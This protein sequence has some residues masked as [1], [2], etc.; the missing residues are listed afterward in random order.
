MFCS[1]ALLIA[2]LCDEDYGFKKS[3]DSNLQMCLSVST[4][5]VKSNL[6]FLSKFYHISITLCLLSGL[7]VGGFCAKWLMLLH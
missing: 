2:T 6:T 1:V 5:Q 3:H 4:V 7:E